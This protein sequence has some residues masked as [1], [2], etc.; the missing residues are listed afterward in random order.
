MSH[1][2]EW[3]R[4]IAKQLKSEAEMVGTQAKSE[5]YEDA[6]RETFI[7]VV[8]EPFL[9]A[10]YAISAGRVIDAAGNIS[11]PQDIVIYRKNYPQFNM[12]GSHNVF[13]YE[14]VL[15]TIQVCSKL[16]RKTFFSALDQCA[17]MS[18]LEPEIDAE[19]LKIM[20][21]KMN[22]Q[23]DEHQRYVHADPL[24]TGRFDLIGRPQTFIYAFTGF[25]TSEKQLTE[26]LNK[27][28]DHYHL[29]HSALQ[30]KSLPAVIATQG[31][32]AWRNTAPF[33]IK[34]RVLMGVGNDI[35]PLRLMFLQLMQ[36]MN[37]GLQN[38]SDGYGIKSSISPYL[39]QF[40]RPEFSSNVGVA[41]NPGTQPAA[42]SPAPQVD[43]P[44]EKT[45][46]QVKESASVVSINSGVND[47]ADTAKPPAEPIKPVIKEEAPVAATAPAPMA[48]QTAA[49][50]TSS[51]IAEPTPTP[52]PTPVSATP[53]AEP[54]PS[55]MAPPAAEPARQEPVI[56]NRS[57]PLPTREDYEAQDA[58]DGRQPPR[59]NPLSVLSGQ[60]QEDVDEYEFIPLEQTT[61]LPDED[62]KAATVNEQ[63]QQHM[64]APAGPADDLPVL[65]PA[66]KP[67]PLGDQQEPAQPGMAASSNQADFEETQEID[68]D[69]S[70]FDAKQKDSEEESDDG[71][72]VDT[73]IEKAEALQD[74]KAEPAPKKSTY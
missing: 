67:A 30:L 16:V 62:D 43:S 36:S 9:P 58:A 45:A 31:C 14:S 10:S 68:S 71:S 46:P 70:R 39:N 48:E 17:S 23:L 28:I 41:E 73:L 63:P 21:T 59:P 65:D 50:D 53:P 49:P 27:W 52:T 51:T 57:K 4:L 55:P 7:R 18:T 38:T 44:S 34:D 1:L 37:R 29:E 20:A 11:E 13:I 6:A 66:I 47:T 5:L 69:V 12:P 26:N 19:T 8:L 33:M 72:F 25:Q 2:E 54:A 64:S 56:E 74:D 60:Q 22:M 61:T 32:F 15:A 24:N 42:P 35:A 40:E 3:A